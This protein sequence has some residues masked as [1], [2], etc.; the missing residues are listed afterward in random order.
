MDRRRDVGEARARCNREACR[1]PT[2][3]TLVQG[4]S[5]ERRR[6]LEDAAREWLDITQYFAR[7]DRNVVTTLLR[8]AA[9]MLW[10][11]YPVRDACD[12]ANGVGYY[13]HCHATRPAASGEHGHFHVFLRASEDAPAT[14]V[15][16]ISVDAHGLPIRACATNR[17]VTGEVVRPAEE[18]LAAVTRMRIETGRARRNVD[19]WLAAVVRLFS[20]QIA[21]LLRQRDGRIAALAD[22][23]RGLEDRRV[24]IWSTCRLSIA[25]QVA[26]LS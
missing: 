25:D 2:A 23:E 24:Q 21:W 4:Y 3:S 19:R 26:A 6:Q 7:R 16:A 11:H 8:G 9:P 13:Y 5:P 1:A 17:W 20:P 14:H 10:K 22:R 12:S 18:L 15:V